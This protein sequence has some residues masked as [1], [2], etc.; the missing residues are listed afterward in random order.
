MERIASFSVDHTK[1]E[2]GVYVSRSDADEKTGCVTTTFDLRMTAP[3]REPVMD[4]AAVH[5]IE[6]LGATFLRNDAEWKDRVIYFGPMGCRTGFYLVLFG[7][8][9]PAD[10][11]DLVLRL[12]EFA[13]DF[14]GEIPGAKPEECGNYHDSDLAQA[15]WWARRYV[16]DTLS[17]LD[18][19]H[20]HYPALLDLDT[21]MENPIGII[22]A[23][24]VEVELLKES[25]A[26]EGAVETS[27]TGQLS[28]FTGTL[29]GAP[30]VVAQCD[31]GMVNAAAH[32]QLIIDR[33]AV[34]GVVNTGVAGSLDASIDIGD[35]VVATDAVNH[36]MDVGNLG[37]AP[38]QT[39]GLSTLAFPADEALRRA[40]V[41]AAAELDIQT[42]EGR[43]ASGDVFVR[44][45]V[46]KNR[47]ADT[48]DASCCEMEGAA[49]AQV[50]W[51]NRV[52]FAI[53]RA[54]SDKADGT[55]YIDYPTF[56]A[57]AARQ[58]AALVTRMIGRLV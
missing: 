4:T 14:E 8:Y 11:A 54:I 2:P 52:P 5:A 7:A 26:A 30:V 16:A 15:K 46:D 43:V 44:E 50:C 12:Y 33:F 10:V 32:T 41:D 22:G 45:D 39:P 3:N 23:M 51:L 57:Q 18:D 27:H 56:E 47:I 9:E 24:D 48:F 49:I 40:A 34:R 37:Y 31:V 36:L 42:W 17:V 38:G 55:D 35:I 20:T 6:H 13:R 29:S 53:V 28:F 1:L 25:M 58:C 19:A 21:S